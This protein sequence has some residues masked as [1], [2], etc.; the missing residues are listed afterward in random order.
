MYV[1]KG[2]VI[3]SLEKS[4]GIS[5]KGMSEDG[6]LITL[7]EVLYSK[8]PVHVEGECGPSKAVPQSSS[9]MQIFMLR[10]LVMLGRAEY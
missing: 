6:S 3:E 7:L 9:A 5:W 4:C 2:R 10:G 8:W 1:R